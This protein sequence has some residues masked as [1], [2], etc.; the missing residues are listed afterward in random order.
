MSEKASTINS[1]LV[2]D[3]IRNVLLER[4]SFHSEV[5][6]IHPKHNEPFFQ[7]VIFFDKFL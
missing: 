2:E 1:Y 7:R 5:H 3:P 4:P 6:S